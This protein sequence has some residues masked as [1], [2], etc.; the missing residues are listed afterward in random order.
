[1]DM[2]SKARVTKAKLNKGQQKASAQQRKEYSEKAT[3]GLGKLFA[4]YISDELI[5]QIYKEFL[6]LNN[7]LNQ[8]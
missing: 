1:M 7:K 5:S 6:Q 3:C 2:T 4:N 8:I